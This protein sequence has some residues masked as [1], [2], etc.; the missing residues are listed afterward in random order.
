MMVWW[1][2]IGI[3]AATCAAYFAFDYAYDYTRSRLILRRALRSNTRGADRM[4]LK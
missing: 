4:N 3:I 1:Q 2:M